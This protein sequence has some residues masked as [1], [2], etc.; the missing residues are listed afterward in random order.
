VI[1]AIN[2]AEITTLRHTEAVRIGT[3]MTTDAMQQISAKK[4]HVRELRMRRRLAS[5]RYDLAHQRPWKRS[6]A[7]AWAVFNLLALA[8]E[9]LG[10]I[11]WPSLGLAAGVVCFA[12]ASYLALAI[13]RVNTVTEARVAKLEARLAVF[14]GV[15]R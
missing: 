6:L 10:L 7:I 1:R 12:L 9:V 2:T 15:L 5:A 14:D 11:V 3:S 13:L 8:C 4:S